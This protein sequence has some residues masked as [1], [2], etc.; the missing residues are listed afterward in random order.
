MT[1]KVKAGQGETLVPWEAILVRDQ[2]NSRTD[3]PK[4]AELAASLSEHGQLTPVLLSPLPEALRKDFPGKL[5]VLIAGSRRMAAFERNA[6]TGRDILATV[7]EH[8]T[9]DPVGRVIDN[10]LENH[11]REDVHCLDEAD[12]VRQLA[13]GT[14]PV[15]PGEEAVEHDRRDVARFFGLTQHQVK[16]MLTLA[17]RIDPWVSGQ[18]R[19]RRV[20]QRVLVA[21]ARIEGHDPFVVAAKQRAALREWVAEKDKLT[22]EGRKRNS[23][24]GGEAKRRG[25]LAEKGEE[26]AQKPVIALGRKV[27]PKGRTAAQYVA[28]L[29]RRIP[30]LN[31]IE[32]ARAEGQLDVFRLLTGALTRIKNVTEEDF[33]ILAE[34]EAEGLEGADGKAAE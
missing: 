12:R 14:Y 19:Q 28:V 22:A 3:L 23:P 18:A 21:W 20:P 16:N 30:E 33:R 26:K 25:K 9:L 7:R 10:F 11:E 31:K 1:T 15:L 6:W 29:G 4:I 17:R 34:V 32:A 8:R 27:D 5:Y 24:A 13:E 2:D